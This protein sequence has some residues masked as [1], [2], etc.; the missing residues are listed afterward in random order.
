MICDTRQIGTGQIVTKNDRKT[1][2][3]ISN[4]GTDKLLS[5]M[6]DTGQIGTRNDYINQVLHINCTAE[7]RRNGRIRQ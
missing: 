6:F 2:L 4:T 1:V 3:I 5:I 7:M